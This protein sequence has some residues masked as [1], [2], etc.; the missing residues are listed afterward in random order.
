MK[1][2]E[3]IDVF[4]NHLATKSLKH[5]D[6]RMVIL[7]VFLSAGKHL[8]AQ[9]LYGI[10]QKKYPSVGFATIYR[11]LRLLCECGVCRELKLEDGTARYE[12]HDE[13]QHHDHLICTQCGK[14]V[15]VVD[16]E[17]E[18]LQDKLFERYG[19]L[20]Q[21]HRLDLYGICKACK[22]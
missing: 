8:T 17:I 15:E 16:P 1:N 20:P 4:R 22:R 3:A 10:V 9:E 21:R 2:K 14:F 12:Y 19:F 13:K 7:E 11:T 5:S 6:Q 18:R